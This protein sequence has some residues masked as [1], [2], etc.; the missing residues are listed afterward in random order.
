MLTRLELSLSDAVLSTNSG[1][2]FQL[3]EDTT[4]EQW[5]AWLNLR[6]REL[7]EVSEAFSRVSSGGGAIT[8]GGARLSE[9]E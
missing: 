1:G 4:E 2:G 9:N 6:L 7:S 3:K 8:V 5:L